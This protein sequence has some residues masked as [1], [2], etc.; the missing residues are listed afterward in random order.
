MNPIR[1]QPVVALALAKTW[2]F[3]GEQQKFVDVMLE[4]LR[5]Q[6]YNDDHTNALSNWAHDYLSE[7]G[8]NPKALELAQDIFELKKQRA[9]A[10]FAALLSEASEI[11]TAAVELHEGRREAAKNRLIA[12]GRRRE[13]W[14]PREVEKYTVLIDQNVPAGQVAK[15]LSGLAYTLQLRN[16]PN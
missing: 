16:P 11:I 12:L 15:T 10:E 3:L 5:E 1:G 13:P 14:F 9:V 6:R 4:T 7:V 8:P 2:R